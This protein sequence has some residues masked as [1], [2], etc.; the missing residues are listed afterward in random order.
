M[1]PLHSGQDPFLE[2]YR[3]TILMK[4]LD[5]IRND[6]KRKYKRNLKKMEIHAITSLKNNGDTVIKPTDKGDSIVIMNRLDYI[7]E[8]LRQ[9]NNTDHYETLDEDPIPTYNEQMLQVLQHGVNLN[10]INEK[11]L[12]NKS[13]RIA[14]FCMLPN[15]HKPNNP[16]IPIVNGI[17]SITKKLSA[18]VDHHL[19]PLVPS[20]IKDSTHKLNLL[21]GMKLAPGDLLVTIDVN[22]LNT[23]IPHNEDISAINRSLEEIETDPLKR[24]DMQTSRFNPH[25]NNF[26]FHSN[27]YIQNY[28]TAMGIKMAPAYANIFMKYLEQGLIATS[29]KKLKMWWRFIDDILMIWSHRRKELNNFIAWANS[30]HPTIKF[31][32]IIYRGRNNDI[33]IKL[34]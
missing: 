26:T 9:L 15:I 18:Y 33:L 13:P 20:Y 21:L 8:G 12:Y 22:S 19:K 6:K 34:V 32:V 24:F 4:T 17:G 29:P 3:S 23:N 25:K 5:V 11:I 1:D 7:Q 27:M 28:D 30:F 2:S 31:S 10:I 16:G 14:N